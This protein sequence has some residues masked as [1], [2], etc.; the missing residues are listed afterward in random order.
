MP[1]FGVSCK[2]FVKTKN[3]LDNKGVFYECIVSIYCKKKLTSKQIE[4]LQHSE[5]P[6]SIVNILSGYE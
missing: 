4:I 3:H 2:S 5:I 1:G 6:S